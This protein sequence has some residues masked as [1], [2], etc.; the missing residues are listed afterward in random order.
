MSYYQELI[1]TI[2][3]ESSVVYYH[4]IFALLLGVIT[5]GGLAIDDRTLMGVNV[6]LK[7]LK[8]CLSTA[9]YLAT[10]GYFTHLYKFTQ[11]KKKLVNHIVSWTLSVELLIIVAQG[12][13]GVQ[14]HYNMSSALD[15]I[16]FGAMG[17]L[18][19][20]NVLVM[21]MFLLDTLRGKPKLGITMNV[22]LLLGWIALIYGSYV[23][24]QMISQ[25][26]H[27]VGVTDGGV[28]MPLVNW[29]LKGGDLR[30]AHFLG[31]HAIQ[32]IPLFSFLL[33]KKYKKS[34]RLVFTASGLFGILYIGMMALTFYQAKQGMPL[35]ALVLN[36]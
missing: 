35:I 33:M 2:K 25:M 23:G 24:G 17:I 31:I 30:I 14:S 4:T 16:L 34:S 3:T 26:S 13:R 27:N 7:P 32:I 20:V 12:A 21:F 29:S 5:V 10:I 9:I 19:A 18:V 36:S 1:S 6:W 11:I 28:G 15:G 22:A 8:F